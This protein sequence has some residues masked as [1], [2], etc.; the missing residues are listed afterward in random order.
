MGLDEIDE[1]E[2]EELLAQRFYSKFEN[3][4]VGLCDDSPAVSINQHQQ[5]LNDADE[6]CKSICRSLHH[7]LEACIYDDYILIATYLIANVDDRCIAGMLQSYIKEEIPILSLKST[8]KSLQVIFNEF[9][10]T[11]NLK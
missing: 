9:Q 2:A 5:I 1:E 11:K 7:E 3:R 6:I 10:L 8:D 4:W